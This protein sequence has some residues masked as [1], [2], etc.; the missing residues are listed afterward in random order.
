MKDIFFNHPAF[1][2]NP[3]RFYSENSILHERDLGIAGDRATILTPERLACAVSGMQNCPWSGTGFFME[4]R[5]DGEQ[6]P[7]RDWVWLPNAILR[8]GKRGNWSATT[9]T[10]IVPR[11]G[12]A[13]LRMA[14]TNISDEAIS[15]PI[16][17]IV[18]GGTR[19]V[20]N[21]AFPIPQG[22]SRHYAAVEADEA[23]GISYLRLTG[24]S[25]DVEGGECSEDAAMLALSCSLDGMKLFRQADMLETVRTVAPGETLMLDITL[26]LGS[27]TGD[28]EKECREVSLSCDEKIGEA[29]AWLQSET[30]RILTRLPKL[31]SDLPGLDS[32]YYRSV[33]TYSLNRWENPNFAWS[34]FY[35]TG[36]ING[37]CMCSYLW[38]YGGGLMLHPLID[39]ESN[40]NMIRAYLHADLTTSFAITPLDGSKTGPWYHI[41]Q[42]KIIQ[43]IY[44]HVLHTGEVDFLYETV[45]GR[46]IWEWAV[47]HAFVLDDVTGPQRLVDYGDEGKSHLELRRKYVYK[48]V[49]PDLN[50]RRYQ[51]YMK[52]YRLT[53]LV[54]KPNELLVERA[55]ALKPL[56]RE[57][58][59]DEDGWY[60]FIWEGERQR[61][62]TVQMFK[63]LDSPVIDD[64]TR[65]KLIAHLNDEEFLSKFGLHSMS[66]KDVAYD[67]V[68]IDNGGG[69][70]CT[71]FT[72]QICGQLYNMGY[73][74]LASQIVKR[75]LWLGTRLPY[76]G[77]SCAANML[78]DREDTPLQADI[79]SAACAQ[80]M[81]FN[82][83]GI[84]PG[85]DGTVSITPAAVLPTGKIRLEDVR[86]FDKVFTL[87]I[88]D[89]QYTV[90][91]GDKTYSEAIGKT[92]VLA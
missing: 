78:E 37:G 3:F 21:W 31:S 59:D 23:D 46:T 47:F 71:Q 86:I 61:R 48:G 84:K 92:V 85:F 32:L 87:A 54:G 12:S 30:D 16:Q 28:T 50:A 90:T 34:P 64:D 63:F 15:A 27:R 91:C 66:K 18:G 38:D 42:E 65:R 40:K 41:N 82:M 77:D 60:D 36:S 2:E 75:V 45:D 7:G 70:I 53:C 55:E 88:S 8:K 68:D 79:S 83:C 19:Y 6:I 57:L 89:G 35:T 67:Q 9:L 39:P 5:I 80:M 26:S 56:L 25:G 76:L 1:S 33:V 49:M 20:E 81:I 69:G 17:I 74:E 62:Y 58:W 10:V 43:M 11:S 4:L 22:V 51:N 52:A 13:I 44:Y 29:F 73:A 24:Y 72:M 14:L